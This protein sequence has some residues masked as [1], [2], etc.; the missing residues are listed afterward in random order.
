MLAAMNRAS[1]KSGAPQPVP[2]DQPR[3][4]AREGQFD[5]SGCILMPKV[6]GFSPMIA[7]AKKRGT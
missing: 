2:Q 1:G 7:A 3:R 6:C 5:E 4:F